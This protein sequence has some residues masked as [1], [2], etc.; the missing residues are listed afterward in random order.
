MS[1]PVVADGHPIPGGVVAAVDET[2]VELQGGV[3]YVLASVIF[4][5]AQAAS[6]DMQTLTAD[7]TRPLH[8]HKEGPRIR[9]AAVDH[10]EAHAA[11]T[12]ILAQRAG[13][14][15]QT[16]TRATLL[17][18]L[19]TELA[20]V[21]VGHLIIESR[22]QREDGRDRATIL[23]CFRN[24]TAPAFT[25]DWRTKAESSLWYPDALAGVARE[26]LTE[27]LSADFNRLHSKLVITDIRHVSWQPP[28]HA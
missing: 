11:G 15:A 7:R 26:H 16:R 6:R 3:T 2:V 8:W 17:S 12:R 20:G 27:G 4:A 13:R 5:D 14:Q 22:G 24:Q 1:N 28:S 21:G 9:E 10:I 19:V 18:E 25:Y 23:D